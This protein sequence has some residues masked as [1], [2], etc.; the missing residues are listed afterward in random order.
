M[1]FFVIVML[2]QIALIVHVI[3]N[4]NETYWIPI[5]LLVPILGALAYILIVV[6]PE[7]VNS[8][9]GRRTQSNF[10]KTLNPKQAMHE[11]QR[12]VQV[13]DTFYNRI[14]F[15]DELINEYRYDEAIEHVNIA[16]TGLYEFDPH[17]METL[18]RAEFGAQR[19]N[20][21]R[22]T[23]DKLIEKNPDH[24]D[25]DAHLLYARI[26][27]RLN[28]ADAAREEY[29]ALI[30]Y[31][32]G[33]EPNVRYAELLIELG[34]EQRAADVLSPVLDKAQWSAKHYKHLHKE[35][36]KKARQLMHQIS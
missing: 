4:H 6:G 26:L 27:A 7:W 18:A 21:A 15:A 9:G 31:Y 30:Q 13:S 36:L 29:D 25:Q 32:T 23:L 20:D 8:S 3:Q 16:L 22:A 11:A 1:P 19:Y 5:L 2:I 34:D 10:K 33:P 35:W 12:N 17:G 28:D 14:T 24:K